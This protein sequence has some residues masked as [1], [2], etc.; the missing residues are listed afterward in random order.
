ML[1][2]PGN[3]AIVQVECGSL[4][5]CILCF[6]C[7]RR[8]SKCM[9]KHSPLI[10]QIVPLTYHLLSKDSIIDK[11]V[12]DTSMLLRHLLSDAFRFL[13]KELNGLFEHDRLQI[14]QLQLEV[15]FNFGYMSF[16]LVLGFLV[17]KFAHLAHTTHSRLID[18]GHS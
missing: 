3:Q 5:V 16:E 17:V 8:Q 18:E 14:F 11:L 10:L 13:P 1:T 15:T 7:W 6:Q 9:L 12:Q 4:I 2:Q